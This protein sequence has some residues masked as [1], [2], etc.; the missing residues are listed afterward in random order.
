MREEFQRKLDARPDTF[1][2]YQY[3]NQLADSRAAIGKYL[4]V[5]KNEVVYVKNATTGVNIVLRNLVYKPGDVIVYFSSVYGACELTIAYL[6]ESTP[7]QA[8]QVPLKFPCTH[9]DIV[10]R[11]L[12]VVRLA[13]E[14]G[15]KVK[16]C[17]LD[18]ISAQPGVRMPFEKIVEK[19]RE[20]GI[21][22][23]IDGAHAVGQIPLDLAALNADFFVSNCHK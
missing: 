23:C 3:A 20:E 4:N 21:L 7:L 15:L 19:C 8:R 14:D 5:P 13:R 18:T 22:S 9:E 1:L 17:L 11:F 10:E 2:R 6:A 12:E 16:V